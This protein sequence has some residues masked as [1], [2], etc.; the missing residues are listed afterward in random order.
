MIVIYRSQYLCDILS[1]ENIVSFYIY[2]LYLYTKEITSLQSIGL[3]YDRTV[4]YRNETLFYLR[5]ILFFF[6][7]FL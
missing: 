2:L 5:S 1:S 6:V 4:I 7:E 3:Y